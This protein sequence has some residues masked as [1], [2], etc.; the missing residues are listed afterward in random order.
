MSAAILYE[1]RSLGP[2][3]GARSTQHASETDRERERF[4]ALLGHELRSPLT[5]IRGAVTLLQEC[6]S[7]LAKLAWIGGVLER[8]TQHLNRLLDDMLDLARVGEGTIRLHK[9]PVELPQIV[10]QAVEGA[11]PWIEECGHRLEVAL[12]PGLGTL[13]ADPTRLVQVLTNL[14]T[15]AA[16][17]TPRGGRISLAAIQDGDDITLEVRDTGIGISP[18]Q[19]AHVFEPFWRAERSVEHSRDGLGI[20]LALVRRLVEAHGGG[21]S[22]FSAGPGRGSKFVVRLPRAALIEE[23]HGAPHDLPPRSCDGSRSQRRQAERGRQGVKQG[24]KRTDQGNNS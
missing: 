3:S 22:A 9:R 13:E 23:D 21:V 18:A 2:T 5:V 12:P 11:R 14:L 20:G 8:Q 7:D 15:N 4:L 6:G 17:Y 24:R 16:K 1:P 19:L 10:A